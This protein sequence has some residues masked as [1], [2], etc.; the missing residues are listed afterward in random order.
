MRGP[1]LFLRF[2]FPLNSGFKEYNLPGTMRDILFH[3][4]EVEQPVLYG[5][6]FTKISP[7]KI[8]G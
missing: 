4:V 6:L 3:L 2:V 1:L 8:N 7:V 5:Y